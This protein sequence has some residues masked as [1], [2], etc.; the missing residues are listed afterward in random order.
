MTGW[1]QINI[2]TGS[3]HGVINDSLEH[4]RRTHTSAN[5]D[6]STDGK[7]VTV[8]GWVASIRSHG[9]ITFVNLRDY[10]GEIQVVAKKGVSSDTVVERLDSVK[11]HTSMSVTGTAKSASKAPGGVEVIPFEV[12]IFSSPFRTPPFEVAAKTVKNID[13][14]LDVRCIDLRRESLQQVFK[15]RTQVLRAFRK[16]FIEN[17]FT[18]ITTPKIIASATEGG[19]AL[20]PIF[21]YDKEAFLAQSPQLYKE[22]LTMSFEKV[23]EIAPIFRAEPSRTRYHLSEAISV[24]MEEAFVDYNDIMDRIAEVIRRVAA[25][26]SVGQDHSESGK[27]PDIGKI[28]RY[29]YTEISDRIRKAGVQIEWGDDLHSSWLNKAGMKGMYFITDWPMGP[30][31]FYVKRSDA[32]KRISESFDLMYDDLELSSGSTRIERREDLEQNLRDKGMNVSAFEHHLRA[33]EYGMPPHAGCGIGLERLMMALLGIS[34]IRDATFYPRDT[35]RL[36]P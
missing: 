29:T 13:T 4:L 30:K 32:D 21:Y 8:M 16:Y 25:A 24:D 19:A 1:R 5:L 6:P 10:T 3:W 22:Q 20:F 28:P 2:A 35:D 31:P 33:F 26:A 17:D 11:P 34:N 9:R 36:Y 18:E 27:M 12:R 15:A 23:F 7:T 14:R